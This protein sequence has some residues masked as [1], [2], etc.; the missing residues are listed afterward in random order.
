MTTFEFFKAQLE[1]AMANGN[2]KYINSEI[3]PGTFKWIKACSEWFFSSAWD[4]Q[5]REVTDIAE[6][7]E[8]KL[9]RVKEYSNWMNRQLGQTRLIVLTN[10]GVKEFYKTMIAT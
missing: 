9:I 10:A 7:K 3:Q 6:M 5:M 2:G 1:K 8:K 4:Y